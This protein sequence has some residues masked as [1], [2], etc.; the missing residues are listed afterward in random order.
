MADM[1]DVLLN[2]LQQKINH[3]QFDIEVD[4]SLQAYL[5][6]LGVIAPKSEPPEPITIGKSDENSFRVYLPFEIDKISSE[7][8]GMLDYFERIG[9]VDC[10]EREQVIESLLQLPQTPVEGHHLLIVMALQLLLKPEKLKDYL[11]MQD[12]LHVNQET[13]H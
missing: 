10:Q 6:E 3:P 5:Q 11:L 8:R 9:L 13:V 4:A 2:L 7:C 1:L 12:L